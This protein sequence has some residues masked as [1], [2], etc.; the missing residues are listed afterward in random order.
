MPYDEFKSSAVELRYDLEILSAR[1]STNIE[2]VCQR[3][4]TLN[5]RTNLDVPFFILNLM[6][7]ETFIVGYFQK[8]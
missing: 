6:R 7:L 8:T 3:L 5:K 4:T 1:F 2:H